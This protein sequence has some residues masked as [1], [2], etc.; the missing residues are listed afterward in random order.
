MSFALLLRVSLVTK[1]GVKNGLFPPMSDWDKLWVLCL[2]CC[3]GHGPFLESS[4][5]V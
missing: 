1:V 2:V 5:H 4:E 3:A